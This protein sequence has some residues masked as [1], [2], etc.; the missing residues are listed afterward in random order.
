MSTPNFPGW[1]PTG[2]QISTMLPAVVRGV[3]LVKT[4]GGAWVVRARVRIAA[5]EVWHL[6]HFTIEQARDANIIER[7]T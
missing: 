3:E 4:E 7:V 5:S 2:S 1:K 6:L